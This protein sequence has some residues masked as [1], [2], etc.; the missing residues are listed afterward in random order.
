MSQSE[1]R[2]KPVALFPA[3]AGF[4][5]AVSLTDEEGS[6]YETATTTRHAP[7]SLLGP[8]FQTPEKMCGTDGTNGTNGTSAANVCSRSPVLLIE[9]PRILISS[10]QGATRRSNPYQPLDDFLS[11]VGRFKII[12]STLRG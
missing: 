1:E 5:M 6:K 8:P 2:M 10:L 9:K 3:A 7:S 4:D 11:N 12:E